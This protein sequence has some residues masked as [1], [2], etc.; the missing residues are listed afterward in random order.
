MRGKRCLVVMV[1]LL[2][3]LGNVTVF[4]NVARATYDYGS[5]K[6]AKVYGFILFTEG[7]LTFQDYVG[8]NVNLSGTDKAEC[9]VSYFVIV[10][11]KSVDHGTL[12]KNLENK[13][14][15]V[16]NPKFKVGWGHEYA[17]LK[18]VFNGKTYIITSFAD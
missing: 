6:N 12:N 3:V 5:G 1:L 15:S 11:N 7:N 16:S 4:A 13:N 9:T 17:K 8:Y 18:L 10:D 14:Y 2:F